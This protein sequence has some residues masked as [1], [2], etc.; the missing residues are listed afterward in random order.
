[1][2]QPMPMT[3]MIA[4]I[5]ANRGGASQDVA[6]RAGVA[7]VDVELGPGDDGHRDQDQHGGRHRDPFE[8]GDGPVSAVADGDLD[9][10]DDGGDGDLPPQLVAAGVNPADQAEQRHDEVQD[11]PGV[12]CRPADGDGRPGWP[13]AGRRRAAEGAAGEQHARR[14]G[15]LPEDDEETEADHADDVSGSARSWCPKAE[16]ELMPRARGSS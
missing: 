6:G 7:P 4:D 10:H 13:P 12:H 15:P 3:V 8:L 16:A 9:G 11:D 14:A 1:M 2:P 5:A